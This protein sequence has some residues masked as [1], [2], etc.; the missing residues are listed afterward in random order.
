MRM[1]GLTER[2]AGL[3][4]EKRRL[5]E[6]MLADA[7]RGVVSGQ[8]SPAEV[9]QIGGAQQKLIEIWATTLGLPSVGVGDNFF[10]LGGDSIQAIQIVAKARREGIDISTNDLFS[11]P[12]IDALLS[13]ASQASKADQGAVYGTTPLTPIQHWFFERAFAESHHWNQSVLLE[14]AQVLDIDA[15]RTAMQALYAHHDALRL[16]FV[17][18]GTGWRQEIMP[19][20]A[21]TLCVEYPIADLAQR[22]GEIEGGFDLRKPPLVCAGLFHGS[23]EK[24]DLLLFA[25]HHLLSDGVSLRILLEDL[26]LAYAQVLG[27][28]TPELPAKTTS[29]IKWAYAIADRAESSEMQG[30]IPYWLQQVHG[31]AAELP[32]DCPSGENLESTAQ[33]VVRTLPTEETMTL[34]R[35]VSRALHAS[36]HEMLLTGLAM[37]L[38]TWTG[39]SALFIETESHGRES[40]LFNLDLDRTVGWFTSL[41]PL[42]IELGDARRLLAALAAVKDAIRNVPGHGL[43]YGLLRY[44][45]SNRL[46]GPYPAAP[47]LFNHLGHFR[48]IDDAHPANPD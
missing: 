10:E 25:I 33:S 5:L 7:E 35:S 1:S 43:G 47:V 32:L 37:T 14:S 34:D 36:L 19:I 27:G 11:S 22:R 8:G 30:E 39:N 6:L 38:Q 21:P 23:G 29:W 3:S 40:A 20:D 9:T 24:R 12:T 26:A 45:Q 41:F 18:H 2:I 44:S 13:R 48:A 15:L 17:P 46:P 16:R 31:S 28:K 42:R 4:P